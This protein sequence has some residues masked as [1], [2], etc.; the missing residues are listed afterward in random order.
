MNMMNVAASTTQTLNAMT[1]GTVLANGA[2]V[3]TVTA[4]ST[5]TPIR[6]YEIT[7]GADASD[8]DIDDDG[9]V[10]VDNALGIEEG[11]YVI[12]VTETDAGWN[13]ATI[14]V[15]IIIEDP[16]S[17][18]GTI[19]G[20]ST[21]T[22]VALNVLLPTNLNFAINPFNVGNTGQ[23]TSAGYRI[24]NRTVAVPVKVEF[25]IEAILHTTVGQLRANTTVE[26]GVFDPN[27]SALNANANKL[28][29]FAALS[30]ITDGTTAP[31]HNGTGGTF[32]YPFTGTTNTI[33][34]NNLAAPFAHEAGPADEH[35]ANIGFVLA[36]AASETALATGTTGIAAFR[37]VGVLNTYAPW[38]ANDVSVSGAY[39]I[40]PLLG[41]TY[42][43]LAATG[44]TGTIA[45]SVNMLTPAP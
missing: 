11:E 6:S 45:N 23:I 30:A 13:D 37:F 17:P 34:D 32:A 14:T 43:N 19:P 25:E 36:G 1:D 31:A 9:V 40:T 41:A 18:T 39:T 2:I 10:T 3:G 38:V 5:A 15:T 21:V 12:I 4:V 20:N 44:A 22:D 35:L 24:I 8:F 28:L 33:T 26:D 29:Y 16:Q 42:T 27:D 7:G